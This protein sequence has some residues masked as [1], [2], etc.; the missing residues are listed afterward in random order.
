MQLQIAKWQVECDLEATQAA[1]ASLAV[2]PDCACNECQNFRAAAGRT[3]TQ[4]LY[5]LFAVLRIDPIKPAELCHWCREP[6]GLYLVGGW[7]HFVGRILEGADAMQHPDGTGTMNFEFL[8]GGAEVALTQHI[9]L[10]PATFRG[11]A[12]CQLEF[13]TRIPWVLAGVEPAP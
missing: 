2:G 1:Y 8:P 3:F 12:V 6:G 10:L 7:F 9:S 5:A 13:Q 4:E 11:L